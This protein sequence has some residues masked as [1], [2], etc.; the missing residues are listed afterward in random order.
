MADQTVTLKAGL[1]NT[2]PYQV[3]GIP[4]VTS[5]IGP[6]V[7]N[8]PNRVTFPS[9]TQAVSVHLITKNEQLR[10]GFSSN[11]VKGTNY[12]LI[13]SN[14]QGIS[15]IELKVRCTD[16]YLLSNNGSVVSASVAASLTGITGYNLGTVYSGSTGVG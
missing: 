7:T 8:A 4:F 5:T 15:F 6:I 1:H 2:G 3:S 16:I 9:V 13:D 10:V 14:T 11:G 12:Y